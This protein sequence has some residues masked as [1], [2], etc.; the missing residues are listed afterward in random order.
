M[1]CTY[2][3]IQIRFGIITF[4]SLILPGF[5]IGSFLN[6]VNSKL[7]DEIKITH[8]VSC[9]DRP[10]ERQSHR[11]HLILKVSDSSNENIIKHVSTVNDFIHRARLDGGVVL[12]HCMM[13]VSRSVSLSMAYIMSVTDLGWR[14]ALNVIR[15]A[16]R[17]A[18]PNFHF[19]RQ[20]HFFENTDLAAERQRMDSLFTNAGNLRKCDMKKC[21]QALE[22]YNR[23]V[24]FGDRLK[25][26]Q[27]SLVID[28]LNSSGNPEQFFL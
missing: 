20:L 1:H 14:D 9:H 6:S 13:G 7:L 26:E 24:E 16:R 25:D 11:Q 8:I 12:I 18:N 4:M 19:R 3:K 22:S 15:S 10:V 5:Y 21:Q 23:W 2:K 17:Q 28:R 27:E